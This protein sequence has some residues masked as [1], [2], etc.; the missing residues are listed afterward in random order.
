MSTKK[1]ACVGIMVADVIV[2]PVFG[3][4]EKGLLLPVNSITMHSGGNAMTAAINL[5]KLGVEST[6]IGRVGDDMFGDYLKGC[7]ERAGVKTNG[8]KLD[9][10][11]Q[12]S[13]SVLMI[14]E[15]TGERSF[16]HCEGSNAVFSMDDIDFDVIAENDIVFVTGTFLLKTF[17]G[18]Q[19]MEFLKKC[20][21]M[22]KITA[23]D[24]CWDATGKWGESLNQVMPYI[25]LFLPSIDEARMLTDKDT[26]EEMANE[27]L[28][29]GVKSVVIKCGSDGCYVRASKEDAGIII[30]I[31]KVENVVDTTGA[32]DSFCSGFLS[33]YARGEEI[34]YCAKFGNATGAHCCMEKGATEGIK[35]YSEILN[36]ITKMENEKC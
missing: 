12:T 5:R 23:L 31:F 16:F 35:S 3:Y 20:K 26:P 36:F 7:L 25:D 24:V 34:L 29:K 19:T 22:G 13:A 28:K 21:E 4:P 33:A 10:S 32:G 11:V 9:G 15:E 1:V 6:L 8:V 2:E 27:F 18:K 30:P 17:D 14:D